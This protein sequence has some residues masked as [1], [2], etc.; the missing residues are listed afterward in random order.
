[1]RNE[2]LGM[3][4]YKGVSMKTLRWAFTAMAIIAIFGFVG[5]GDGDENE[6]VAQPT[7]SPGAGS[8]DAAQTVTL[9]C[10]TNGADIYYSI[11]GSAPSTA[12]TIPITISE[13]TTLK[14]IA[15][16]DGMNDSTVL[17]AVY[18]ITETPEPREATINLDFI[19]AGEPEQC[20]ATVKGT[21]TTAQWEGI[22]TKI[23]TAIQNG[24]NSSS[25][26]R[27]GRFYEVFG[28]NMAVIVVEK[29][30]AF[31]KWHVS[32][33]Y[34]INFNFDWLVGLLDEELATSLTDA[35]LEMREANMPEAELYTKG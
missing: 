19:V 4:N 5:C 6:T 34:L 2:K 17:T 21:L 9:E 31:E 29:T 11:D 15:K 27:K 20:T 8:Y 13:T 3:R 23:K 18:T 7:A 32:N 22:A 10:A 16:K 30:T 28:Q 1:M 35:I 33:K 12:Y 26:S 14:A 25:I 24:Y